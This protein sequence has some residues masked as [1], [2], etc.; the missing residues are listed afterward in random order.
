MDKKQT[1]E[2]ILP[3]L[4]LTASSFGIAALLMLVIGFNPLKAY[5]ALLEGAFG[6]G[7]AVITT[8]NK[9]IPIC[10]AAFAVGL[11]AKAG[12]FNIGV[13]GQLVMGAFGAAVAGIYITGLPAPLHI[14]LSM[15]A[16]A[17]A[18]GL[19]ALIPSVLYV[20]RGTNL[21]VSAI[22]SNNIA[23]LLLT[24]LVVG[25]FKGE[26]AIPS[27]A[28][29]QSTAVLPALIE[30][31]ARLTIAAPLVLVV[32]IIYYLYMQ[33]T[34]S[35]YE[36]RAVGQNPAAARFVGIHNERYL[37]FSL[38]GGGMLAGIAGSIEVLGNYH[39][40]FDGFSPGYGFDG[41]PIALISNGN[42]FI[43][44]VG[45]LLFGGL[46]AGSQNM[47]M[48]AGVKKEIVTVIQGL[49]IVFIAMQYLFKDGVH[50]MMSKTKWGRG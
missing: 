7:F 5:E 6:S 38:V 11:A 4:L 45:S 19:W 9:S 28:M 43:M 21:I 8:I 20:K 35:G 17:I 47:Q 30:V 14:P 15:L 12:V 1:L 41:I 23:S 33:R 3:P 39:Q 18:G 31:P 16:G 2:K 46:R 32:G 50:R 27:T 34:V 42:P 10:I 26:Q 49:L 48:M 22:L 40:L 13:E 37:L 24:Y 29:I 36:L 44:M 25:P